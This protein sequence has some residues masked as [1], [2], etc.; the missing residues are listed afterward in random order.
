MRETRELSWLAP[1]LMLAFA[2]TGCGE[3]A[4]ASSKA[5]DSASSPAFESAAQS[6]D[7]LPVPQGYIESC[8]DYVILKSALG[9]PFWSQHWLNLAQ[10]TPA[11][12]TWCADYVTENPSAPQ[13]M[14]DEY[15]MITAYLAAAATTNPPATAPQ[16]TTPIVTAAPTPVQPFVSIP[17]APAPPQ[18]GDCDPNYGGCVPIASDVDCADGSGNGPAY[19]SGPVAVIGTDVYGLDRDGNGWGCE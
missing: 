1:T 14:Q 12:Q 17:P 6:T 3:L 8:A 18:S 13:Q 15:Q 19:T 5:D 11:L 10:S 7:P 16:V 9:D 4:P 2:V